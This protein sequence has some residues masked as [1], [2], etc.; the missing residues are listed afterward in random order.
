MVALAT[1]APKP[2]ATNPEPVAKHSAAPAWL[3]GVLLFS[4]GQAANAQLAH[5]G[6]TGLISTPTPE[7]LQQGHLSFGF[8]WLNGNN[9]YLFSPKTNRVFA[10]T[11]GILPGIEATLRQTQVVGWYPG[12]AP[13]VTYGFDRMFSAKYAV[14]LPNGLPKVAIGIQDLASAN[15]L[16]GRPGLKPGATQYGQTTAYGVLGDTYNSWAWHGGFGSSHAFIDGF[17]AGVSYQPIE[18]LSILSE[19]DSKYLNLG[20]RVLLLDDWWIQVSRI[21]L[22]TWGISSGL[23][24]SL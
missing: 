4:H 15:Y 21:G 20:F 12:D 2:A 18:R 17:F 3:C 10:V 9:T 6:Y 23:N 22:E 24:I 7:V 16:L 1:A 13:G 8:S 5:P 14:S 11:I 19:W